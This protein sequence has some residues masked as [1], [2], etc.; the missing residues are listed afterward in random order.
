MPR[1]RRQK[2]NTRKRKRVS[3]RTASEDYS[4]GKGSNYLRP[5]EGLATFKP[6]AKKYRLDFMPYVV[7]KGNPVASEGDE[8]YERK[9]FVHK[10]VGPDEDWVICPAKTFKKPCPICEY[11]KKK[12]SD[13]DMDPD[14][15]KEMR[16][17]LG[18]K[19]R[20]LYLVRDLSDGV[21]SPV[22]LYNES[23]YT[24]GKV[25]FGKID[26]ADEEDGYDFFADPEEGLT[27]RVS[28]K[29]ADAGKW[30]E[31]SDLELRQRK[32]KYDP[33][34]AETLPC[35][36]EMLVEIPYD[37]MKKMFLQIE[38]DEVGDDD[39]DDPP[40]KRKDG[41]AKAEEYG[42]EKGDVVLYDGD[43]ECTVVRVSSDGT[44]L[45]LEDSD[46]ELIKSV[47][48]DEVK[49]V[50]QSSN[51]DVDDDD[52]PPEKESKKAAPEKKPTKK[53][54]TKKRPTKKP[55]KKKVEEAEP[56]DDDDDDDDS[57]G[58]DDD[59]LDDVDDADVLD[60]NDDGDDWDDFDDDDDDD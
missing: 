30:L 44:S 52:P 21:D 60:N 57:G 46:G 38:A 26:N 18:S 14:E 25:L 29:N 9:F 32:H 50:P 56:D 33:N 7:G 27:V 51:D 45:I 23:V 19:E 17:N 11:L 39:V 58:F 36:D 53:K 47:G 43:D 31:V 24:F 28:F 13:E 37:R 20:R 16:S 42:I 55:T 54:P 15:W 34:I 6:E 35:L 48:P 2:E 40:K 12:G 1:N 10:N 49:K 3:A 4:A 41:F 5:P 59:E 8:F 22:M